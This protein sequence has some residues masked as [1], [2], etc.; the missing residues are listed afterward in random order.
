[1]WPVL[2]REFFGPFPSIVKV[3]GNGIFY[4]FGCAARKKLIVG[5]ENGGSA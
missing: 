3:D 4:A 1:M 2:K 5:K